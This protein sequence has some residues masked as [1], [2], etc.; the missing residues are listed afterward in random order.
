MTR[1]RKG[2]STIIGAAIFVGILLIAFSSLQFF[3][4]DLSAL[5]DSYSKMTM[6]DED[7]RK[8][9]LVIDKIALAQ[10]SS[11]LATIS[12]TS[13]SGAALYPLINM[14]F[15]DNANGWVFS[16]DLYDPDTPPA[17][18][19]TLTNADED[20]DG[21]TNDDKELDSPN[22]KGVLPDGGFTAGWSDATIPSQSGAGSVF[23]HFS[24]V[25]N[26]NN[27]EGGAL[28]KWTSKFTLDSSTAAAISS[29]TF[30]IGYYIP[31]A[32]QVKGPAQSDKAIIFYT[33]TFPTQPTP[34]TYA[35]EIEEEKDTLSWNRKEIPSSRLRDSNN[36]PIPSPWPAGEY[37]LQVAVMVD[38][39]AK[40]PTDKEVAEFK[41][42]FDDVG[43]K[44]N[45]AS[46][47]SQSIK[48]NS[49][50]LNPFD[51]IKDNPYK[52]NIS[53]SPE[54]IT[55]LDF[56]IQASATAS[57]TQYVFLYDFARSEWTLLLSSS[58]SSS[59]S[60][61]KLTKASLD[62]PRFVAQVAGGYTVDGATVTAAVGDVWVRIIVSAPT[63]TQFTY[64][65][66]LSLNTQIIQNNN[67]SFVISNHGGITAHIVKYWIVTGAQTTS[68]DAD[69]YLDPGKSVTLS[70]AITPASGSIEIRVITERGSIASLISTV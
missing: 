27:D 40:K 25:S 28:M 24:M 48:R 38:V 55:S 18:P 54:T 41:V 61:V 64:T 47:S 37:K 52:F 67:V 19:I 6:L 46:G 43:I 14:N 7:R 26:D 45:L 33:I 11:D 35:I 21:S 15:T 32:F 12:A 39:N 58:V 31:A 62:V 10:L 4:K 56:S 5:S 50:D 23:T 49:Y 44:L 2:V 70:Q 8:E 17:A 63:S 3:M 30:S 20:N 69:T 42:F 53:S 36:Q 34:K 16:A 22:N 29:A 13:A 59:T 1:Q 51:S 60:N 66:T 68:I 65:G 9:T 57:A